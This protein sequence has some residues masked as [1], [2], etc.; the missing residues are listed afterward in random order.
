MRHTNFRS[1]TLI[2]TIV[3]LVSIGFGIP[4]VQKVS[5]VWNRPENWGHNAAADARRIFLSGI[6]VRLGLDPTE[7]ESLMTAYET[8]EAQHVPMDM[9]TNH[10][11]GKYS[12]FATMYP[13]TLA[14]LAAP[15]AKN[16]WIWFL[17]WWRYILFSTF[18]MGIVGAGL[19]S[20]RGR[21]APIAGA[22]C[23][24]FGMN[25]P[26]NILDISLRLGQANL[27]VAGSFGLMMCMCS[28][29]LFRSAASVALLGGSVKIVPVIGLIPP[30]S[31][32]FNRVWLWVGISIIGIVLFV[33]N[34]TPVE[35]FFEDLILILNQQ[36]MARS[37]LIINASDFMLWLESIRVLPLFCMSFLLSSI[38]VFRSRRD[39]EA[40]RS[41]TACGTA[42]LSLWLGTSAS[43]IMEHYSI[44]LVPGMLFLASWPFKEKSP[45]WSWIMVLGY[46]GPGYLVPQELFNAHELISLFY[47]GMVFWCLVA[48]RLLYEVRHWFRIHDYIFVGLSVCALSF[49]G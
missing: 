13:A 32:L 41:A 36:K 10:A 9:P 31:S 18:V 44:L 46:L 23:L 42:L 20:A 35:R 29:G 30:L 14:P 33:S 8:K 17:Y 11:N 16:N 21:W 12:D 39:K 28:L 7:P 43:A 37:H 48:F 6:S 49:I 19:G 27:L 34:W 1:Q 38:A 24:F 2:V 22:L 45:W 3:F 5:D 15:F 47:T 25:T 26:H 4:A 40:L